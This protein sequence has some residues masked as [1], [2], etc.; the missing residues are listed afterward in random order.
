MFQQTKN[1][2]NGGQETKYNFIC[3]SQKELAIL[4]SI[5]LQFILIYFSLIAYVNHARIRSWNQPVLSN[6][7]K[8]SCS[9]KQRGPLM[10]LELT[11][12]RYPPITSPTRYAASIYLYKCIWT[13]HEMKVSTFVKTDSGFS[14]FHMVQKENMIIFIW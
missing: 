8:V 3:V 2:Q 6:Q 10:G 14:S 9:R 7:S 12:N 11:T 4:T 1:I 5:Y 13:R